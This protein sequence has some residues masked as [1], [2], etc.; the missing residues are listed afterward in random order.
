MILHIPLCME[1]D[2][3]EYKYEYE[4]ERYKIDTVYD[5]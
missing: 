3:S 1:M 5:E 4:Y 2:I